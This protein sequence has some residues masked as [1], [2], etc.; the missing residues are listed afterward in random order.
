MRRT[1]IVLVCLFA[2]GLVAYSVLR[3]A[4]GFTPS[5]DTPETSCLVTAIVGDK[6]T[7]EIVVHNNGWGTLALG[8][9]KAPAGVKIEGVNTTVGWLRQTSVR[10]VVDT[11]AIA[12]KGN[13]PFKVQTNDAKRPELALE[14]KFDIKAYLAA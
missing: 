8:G 4:G 1:W 13:I 12:G 6:A 7:C 9:A 3:P 5:A 14:V 10:A 2:V 11:D